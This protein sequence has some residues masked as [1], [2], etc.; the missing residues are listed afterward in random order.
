[1]KIQEAQDRFIQSWGQL[2]AS[3][4]IN[5]TMAQIQ[6]LLLVSPEPLST[7][8]IMEALTISRGNA[9]MNVRELMAW[10]LVYK[11]FVPG[12]RKEFFYAEKNMWDIAKKVSRERKKRELEPILRMLDEVKQV[13]GT[14]AASKEFRKVTKDVKSMAKKADSALGLVARLEE[15]VFFKWLNKK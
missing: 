8:D 13:E 10:G 12:E 7:D 1:V 4:G 6:A 9:N 15:N 5:R 3:W 14:D 2:G 11:S